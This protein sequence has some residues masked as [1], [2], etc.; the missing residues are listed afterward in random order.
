VPRPGARRRPSRCCR[1]WKAALARNVLIQ[2][3]PARCRGRAAR[4]ARCGDRP[5]QYPCGI[6]KKY[7]KSKR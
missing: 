5:R 2:S 3:G 6:A 7:A 4:A 1:T